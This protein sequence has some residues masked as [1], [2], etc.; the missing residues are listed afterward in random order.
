[1]LLEKP[2]VIVR[3]GS[4]MN[5]CRRTSSAMSTSSLDRWRWRR[6]R[7]FASI[8]FRI[9]HWII[10]RKHVWVCISGFHIRQVSRPLLLLLVVR[11]RGSTFVVL[12]MS[13]WCVS[14]RGGS[15]TSRRRR[16]GGCRWWYMAGGN[17]GGISRNI[18][19]KSRSRPISCGSREIL[20]K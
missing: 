17:I 16:T 2:C 4:S 10:L 1:M 13:L 12:K 3:V 5:S 15:R 14:G 19:R 20:L 11:R 9:L 7:R 8:S 18:S 6:R